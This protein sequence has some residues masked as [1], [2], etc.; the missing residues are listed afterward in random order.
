MKKILISTGGTGGHVMPALALYDH[1]KNNF[2]T[3]IT[4]DKRGLKFI[5][6]EN[7]PCH[8][9][10]TPQILKNKLILPINLVLLIFKLFTSLFF[11]KKF[12]IDYV[13]STGGYMSLPICLA[14][15]ILNLKIILFEPNMV[16]GKSNKLFLKYASK[17]IC[18]SDKLMNF[19]ENLKDKIYIINPLLRKKIYSK[20]KKNIKKN[21][22]ILKILIIGGSQGA[23]FFDKKIS[24]IIIG[25][26][27]KIKIFVI[28][29][30]VDKHNQSEIK[31]NYDKNYIDNFL[32]EFDDKIFDKF[33]DID[34]AISRSGASTIFELAE[35]K[36]P[37][38]AVPLPNSKDNH[39]YYNAK[40]FSDKNCCWLINQSE[41][42]NIEIKKFI[43]NLLT[44]RE[45][46]FLK[47]QN[48]TKFSYQN[49]WN[50]VNQKL[51][52][53]INEN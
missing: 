12:K 29:Q 52:S 19:P 26:N 5:D 21:N 17:I 1:Y 25:I 11:L 14:A 18:Y 48:M 33:H 36:I 10:N 42:E 35:L 47:K 20:N 13:V 24:D 8:I 37:F 3:F 50:N 45:E 31:T 9:I 46:I 40:Y 4:T 34:L 15:K 32:F 51:I 39:Q 22:K 41:F 7:Y 27:K 38:I 28:H 6:R 23:K 30:I 16:L 53:L 49:S 2:N 43:N 44:N